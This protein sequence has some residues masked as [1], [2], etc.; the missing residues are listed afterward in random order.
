MSSLVKCFIIIFI[1]LPLHFCAKVKRTSIDVTTPSGFLLNQLL[2]TLSKTSSPSSLTGSSSQNPAGINSFDTTSQTIL[3]RAM[4]QATFPA[5]WIHY[6]QKTD[7][8]YS[9]C[10][11][12]SLSQSK[13]TCFNSGEFFELEIPNIQSCESISISDNLHAFSWYCIQENEKIFARSR[14]LN[15]YINL[16]DLFDLTN[17]LWKDIFIIVQYNNHIHLKTTPAKWWTNSIEVDSKDNTFKKDSIY[18]FTTSLNKEINII[19]PN[20]SL[21]FFSSSDIPEQ[22]FPGPFINLQ[23][24]ANFTRIEGTIDASNF[25]GGIYIGSKFTK[26]TNIQLQD[27]KTDEKNCPSSHGILLSISAENSTLENIIIANFGGNAL[28]IE[29]NQNLISNI[30]LYNNTNSGLY[31]SSNKNNISNVSSF[32]ND[33]D[34]IQIENSQDIILINALFVNNKKSGLNIKNSS[35]LFTMNTTAANNKDG[36]FIINNDDSIFV[37]LF[38]LYNSIFL[39][40]SESNSNLT[41]LGKTKLFSYSPNCNNMANTNCNSKGNNVAQST[42]VELLN[43][44]FIGSS[45]NSFSFDYTTIKN[46]A[47][48]ISIFTGIGKNDPKNSSNW[49]G[50]QGRC[51]KS[52][53]CEIMNWRLTTRDTLIKSNN[54][55]PTENSF[56]ELKYSNGSSDIALMNAIEL[57]GNNNTLCELG[58]SCLYTPN[59]ASYQGQG[60]LIPISQGS[61]CSD[62]INLNNQQISLYKYETNGE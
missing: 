56:V 3:P 38:S 12:N 43:N 2:F 39:L 61:N 59:S 62:S 30:A 47:Q 10:D 57:K 35:N 48:Q 31:I 16:I 29:S 53:Q 45:S 5:Q 7:K 36:F 42:G 24:T 25:C 22:H 50:S 27:K 44:T 26:I 15:H 4:Y 13:E 46:W 52:D 33:G 40:K 18:I 20:I 37:N 32:N 28:R 11:I 34:G 1:V 55:C 51:S 19:E 14:G 60:K 41:F 23:P 58:E 21:F 8:G 49:I 6:I 54:D 17:K 9:N